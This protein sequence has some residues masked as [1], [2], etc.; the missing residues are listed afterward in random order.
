MPIRSE[1]WDGET[2][3]GGLYGVGFDRV[4]CGESMFSRADNASKLALAW[5]VAAM[6][7]A[8]ME[9]LDCQFMTEHLASLGAVEISQDDYCERWRGLR[10]PARRR[11]I[12]PAPALPARACG[13]GG[14][15]AGRL[16]AAGRRA[17]PLRP[18]SSSRS[19]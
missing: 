18:G 6:R 8:G 17:A 3:I 1:V 11:A 5:L 13:R 15:A 7:F 4:F 9:L 2:L 19:S 12:P 14:G 10:P 16:R